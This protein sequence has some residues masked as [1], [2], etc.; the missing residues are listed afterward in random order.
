[1]KKID[2]SELS[3]FR[4]AGGVEKR[5]KAVIDEDVLKE[6]VGIG[7]VDVRTALPADYEKYPTVIRKEDGQ[8]E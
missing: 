2:A 4:M 3:N 6:W 5:I 8:L 1:M 7:W